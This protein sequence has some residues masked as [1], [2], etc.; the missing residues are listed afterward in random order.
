MGIM[1]GSLVEE[2]KERQSGISVCQK[3]EVIT[4]IPAVT[5]GIPSDRA[6]R[7]RKVAITV[8]VE[9]AV[10]PAITGM[11][12]A[13]TGGSDNRSTIAGDVKHMG[14][15]LSTADG[16]IQ[17]A[18]TEDPKKEAVSFLIYTEGSPGKANN[19]FSNG[20]LLL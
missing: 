15:Y 13:K 14:I 1:F 8:A 19:E 7:L 9:I 4:E 2:R 20:F 16:F 5:G 11:V 17:E 3:I 12:G 18:C 10:F 6:I